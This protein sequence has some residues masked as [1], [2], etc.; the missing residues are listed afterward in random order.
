MQIQKIESLDILAPYRTQI[1]YDNLNEIK[2]LLRSAF[3]RYHLDELR[4]RIPLSH[5][6]K[7]RRGNKVYLVR[8]L[9]RMLKSLDDLIRQIV[10]NTKLD[11]DNSAIIKVM[12]T[13]NGLV[14]QIQDM[15]QI[16]FE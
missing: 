3:V 10:K 9:Q 14:D 5:Y 8:R 16:I 7:L 12:I 4:L 2:I 11:L 15:L 13:S 6:T 1:E